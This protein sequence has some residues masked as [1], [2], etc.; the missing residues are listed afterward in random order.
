MET[1]RYRAIPVGYPLRLFAQDDLAAQ[2]GGIGHDGSISL[3]RK[4]GTRPGDAHRGS[5]YS[6]TEDCFP[7]DK[8]NEGKESGAQK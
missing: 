4:I 6:A 5:F 2:A 8:R 7:L 3:D 1:L